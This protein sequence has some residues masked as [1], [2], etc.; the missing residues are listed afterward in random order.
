MPKKDLEAI[1]SN[2]K[3]IH[4]NDGYDYSLITK[5][6]YINTNQKV[7]IICSKHGVFYQTLHAHLH[8]GCPLCGNMKKSKSMNN[9]PRKD[10]R[11]KVFG[12]GIFDLDKSMYDN[13][14][15][16]FYSLWV[17]MIRRCYDVKYKKIK[18]SYKNCQVCDDWKYFSNFLTWCNDAKNNYHE[19]Y[20]LD[21]DILFKD[22]KIYSPETCCF[23]PKQINILLINGKEKRKNKNNDCP[24]GVTFYKG[25]YYARLSKKG[26]VFKIGKFANQID[27]FNAYKNERECYIKSIASEYYILGKINEKIYNALMNY[28]VDIND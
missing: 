22:N 15:K 8:Q 21:K 7:P 28:K 10:L 27:A 17:N 3:S 14:I 2:L 13:G 16:E 25:M 4:M 24:I 9:V 20:Q 11:N 23:V 1:V 12:W 19:G 18:T 5:S 6:N 26:Q